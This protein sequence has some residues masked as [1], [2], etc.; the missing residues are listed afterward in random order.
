MSKNE[1]WIKLYR[2]I[3]YDDDWNDEP[4]TLGQA[5]VDILL[6]VNH[7]TGYWKD[8]QIQ[9]GQ[10][11]TSKNKLERFWRVG[12]VKVN[13]FLNRMVESEKI[14]L[15]Y[16]SNGLMITVLNY[17][18]YQ[19]TSSV[20]PNLQTNLQPKLQTRKQTKLQPTNK[21]DKEC[22]KNDKEKERRVTFPVRVIEDI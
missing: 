11:W 20:Q 7:K 12:H 10:M 6:R 15:D 22:N 16:H 19:T 3:I 8:K 5:W 1:G 21:N 2:G 18:K 14:K 4:F 9:R 17:D 13:R